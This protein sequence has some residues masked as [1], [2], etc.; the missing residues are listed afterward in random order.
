MLR[1][2]NLSVNPG[3]KIAFVGPTG[4]GKSTL[5]SL[6]PRFYDP[7]EGRVLVDDLDVREYQLK[8]L[9]G[10][11]SMVLQPPL[12]FPVSIRENISYGRPEAGIEEIVSAAKLARIH[13]SIE[14]LPEQYETMVGEQGATLSEGERQRITIARALLRDSPILILDEPT[15]SVDTETESLIMEGLEQLTRGRTTF[16]IAH[17]LSTVAQGG[18]DRCAW[19]RRDHRAGDF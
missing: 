1:G 11:I 17:R 10:Q 4:V 19:Q 7:K 3:E 14:R 5:V 13:D 18:Q 12:V 2:I 6:I 9:R 8:S 15:S 16:I